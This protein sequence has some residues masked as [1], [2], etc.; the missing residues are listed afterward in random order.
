MS[1]KRK[2]IDHEIKARV[3]LE[4]IQNNKTTA[5]IS[6]NYEVQSSQINLWKKKLIEA[7]PEIFE[8]KRLKESRE[9]DFD[10]REEEYQKQI[11][12]MQ[13]DIEWLKK[14]LNN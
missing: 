4:A 14:S 2:N 9:K 8:D 13:M 3:A 12:K 6:S 1:Q 7:A 10:K 5:E 11:G